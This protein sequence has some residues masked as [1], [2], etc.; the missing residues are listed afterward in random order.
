MKDIDKYLY[1]ELKRSEVDIPNEI[2][3]E[4]NYTLNK[5]NTNKKYKFKVLRPSLAT[6][7]LLVTIIPSS[8]A[9]SKSIVYF[10]SKNVAYRNTIADKP[11]SELYDEHNNIKLMIE[12]LSIDGNFIDINYTIENKNGIKDKVIL[13]PINNKI[14]GFENDNKPILYVEF[15]DKKNSEISSLNIDA[16]LES[17]NMV[18]LKQRINLIDTDTK[19]VYQDN[20]KIK[21]TAYDLFETEGE[22]TIN[23]TD[24]VPEDLKLVN[25]DEKIILNK[26]KNDNLKV[27]KLTI[28]PYGNQMVVYQTES[29]LNGYGTA[30]QFS[31]RDDKGKNIQILNESL[32]NDLIEGYYKN[33]FEIT[34]FEEDTKYIELISYKINEIVEFSTEK[35]D[36]EDNKSIK[37]SDTSSLNIK[38][39]NINDKE[40]KI[41]YYSESMIL[42]SV[43]FDFYDKYNKK[44][45]L[46]NSDVEIIDRENGIYRYT[47]STLHTK[48]LK[49]MSISGFDYIIEAYDSQALKIHINQ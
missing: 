1:N 19:D 26:F 7:M 21:I 27:D 41:D 43:E 35:F 3:K 6:I 45:G 47:A 33:I 5:I 32:S 38:S 9:L 17:K 24:I 23:L 22:W 18:R 39:I 28:S 20:L 12:E 37:I 13:N 2:E 46:D 4:I 48:G 8:Y 36:I 11:I 15:N 25:I 44:I 10:E 29:N 34:R 31:L 16:Y 49:K 14:I 42:P 30:Y 40:I